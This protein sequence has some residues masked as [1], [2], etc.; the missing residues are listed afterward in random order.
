MKKFYEVLFNSNE[1][2]LIKSYMESHELTLEFMKE[3]V[4]SQHCEMFLTYVHSKMYNQQEEAS[5]PVADVEA[6]FDKF[7]FLR[8]NVAK[9][10]C[11]RMSASA[12]NLLRR[13]ERVLE[14][15]DVL[16]WGQIYTENQKVVKLLS[17]EEY[18]VL[19]ANV[20]R[21]FGRKVYDIPY[22]NSILTPM[23][24]DYSQKKAAKEQVEKEMAESTA[25]EHKLNAPIS[26]VFGK[27]TEFYQG[28]SRSGKNR[29]TR[30]LNKLGERSISELKEFSPEGIK[31]ELKTNEL[32][33]TFQ[34]CIQAYA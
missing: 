34:I 12:Q 13:V 8:I 3:V 16:Y 2:G 21:C 29:L 33:E 31:S 24:S 9:L 30:I 25:R 18:H 15:N 11:E 14:G 20:E 23:L 6:T 19:S 17:P 10:F 5:A 4:K 32:V 22:I 27:D 7:L 28:L 1:K 26:E